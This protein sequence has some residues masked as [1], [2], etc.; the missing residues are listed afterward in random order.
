VEPAAQTAVEPAVGESLAEAASSRLVLS[1]TERSAEQEPNNRRSSTSQS[2][3]VPGKKTMNSRLS[4]HHRLRH[5]CRPE[6]EKQP[7]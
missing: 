4:N 5:L 2:R 6:P 7:R 3:C 1:K